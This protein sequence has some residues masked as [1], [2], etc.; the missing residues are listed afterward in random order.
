[1]I[2]KF[3]LQILAVKMELTRSRHT[4]KQYFACTP[5]KG[6]NLLNENECLLA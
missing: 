3:E 2:S 1:M 5:I 4:K 6:L